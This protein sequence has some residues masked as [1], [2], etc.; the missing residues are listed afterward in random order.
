M[1]LPP[2]TNKTD[3]LQKM[4]RQLR[5]VFLEEM[6]ER[7]DMIDNMLLTM[8]KQHAATDEGFNDLYRSIHSIKGSGGTHGIHVISTICHQFEDQLNTVTDHLSELPPEFF[9]RAFDYIGL[10]RAAVDQARRG[11]DSFPEIEK[12]LLELHGKTFAVE[13]SLLLVDAARFGAKLYAQ[14][15]SDLPVHIVVM[16]NG[17]D[18]L[19]RVLNEPF[20]VLITSLE[21]PVL[22]GRALIGA[23]RL[24]GSRNRN[25]RTILLTSNPELEKHK[26]RMTDANYVIVKNATFVARLHGTVSEIISELGRKSS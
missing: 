10:I 6:A 1:G 5:N 17:Y 20:D 24:S 25:I 3:M 26:Q 9:D 2:G 13:H 4:L 15:L 19:L 11:A 14:A 16:D 12:K 7:L 18:A 8:E 21:L 22:N 23:L